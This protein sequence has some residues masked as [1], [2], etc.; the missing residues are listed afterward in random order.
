LF[1]NT[2]ALAVATLLEKHTR[3]SRLVPSVP[4]GPNSKKP[5]EKVP[6]LLPRTL[7]ISTS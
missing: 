7:S 2:A 5:M 1:R 6:G 3:T 4:I